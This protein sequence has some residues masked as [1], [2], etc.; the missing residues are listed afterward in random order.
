MASSAF[1][2]LA[3]Q[4]FH[5]GGSGLS[6]PA[7]AAYVGI[8]IDDCLDNLESIATPDLSSLRYVIIS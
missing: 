6:E 4:L 2:P 7:I 3:P 5:V 1:D 8:F